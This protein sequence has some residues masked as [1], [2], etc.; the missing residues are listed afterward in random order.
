MASD[1]TSG[2]FPWP[3]ASV[4]VTHCVILGGS[5][6]SDAQTVIHNQPSPRAQAEKQ[7]RGL[8]GMAR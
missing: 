3:C 5:L 2:C 1:L 8:A 6:G 4:A 7:V